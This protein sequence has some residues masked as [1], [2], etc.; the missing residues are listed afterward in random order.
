MS[1]YAIRVCKT[2][3]EGWAHLEK[4]LAKVEVLYPA[5]PL[6][7][8]HP[9]RAG[10]RLR[11]CFVGADFMRKGGPILLRAHAELRRRGVPVDTTIVSKLLWSADDYIGP[12]SQTVYLVEKRLVD[13]EGVKVETG[14]PNEATLRVMSDSDYL[15]FPTFHDTFGFVSIEAMA[16]GTPV[17]AHDT[18]AQPEIIEDKVSGVLLPFDNSP[19]GDWTWLHKTQ[20]PEYTEAYV[21]QTRVSS[22]NLADSLEQL[23]A[24]KDAYEE[25]SSGAIERVRDRF[26]RVKARDRLEAIYELCRE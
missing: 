5:L 21:E 10:D 22:I 3:H 25:M 24:N 26:D 18:C 7:E 6:R 11:L 2:Q 13:A 1:E 14:L 23:W 20:S 16:G 17:I 15:V 8:T 12:P 19:I 4:L 9:K